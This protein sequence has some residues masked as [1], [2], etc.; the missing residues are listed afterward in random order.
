MMRKTSSTD[1]LGLMPM[2]NT[3]SDSPSVVALR[4]GLCAE[5]ALRPARREFINST[6]QKYLRPEFPSLGIRIL[7]ST[8]ILIFAQALERCI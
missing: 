7:Y 3:S 2:E 8:Q 5:C 4:R 6:W 1:N